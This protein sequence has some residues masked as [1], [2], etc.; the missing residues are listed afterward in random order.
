MMYGLVNQ[1]IKDLVT[2]RFGEEQWRAICTSNNISEEDFVSLQYYPDPLTYGLVGAAST[3]L[4]IP[5]TTILQEFGKHWVLYTAQV[6]YGPMLD[7]FGSDLPS[8]LKNLN[9]LHA[10]MGMT[11][12]D[13]SP[14]RFIFKE[15]SPTQMQIEYQS[16]RAGLSPMVQGLLEGLALKFNVKAQ[17]RRLETDPNDKLV[18]FE[19]VIVG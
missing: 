8:C 7:L 19:I 14:P 11:M 18:T 2:T 10:R 5:A 12:P 15:I 4:K 13:L 3:Q 16:K 9:N 6:G 1:A 17:I